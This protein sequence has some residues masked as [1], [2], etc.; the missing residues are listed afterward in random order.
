[1]VVGWEASKLQYLN[2]KTTLVNSYRISCG[3]MKD[4]M[5]REYL[6]KFNQLQKLRLCKSDVNYS[7][8]LR[9][10]MFF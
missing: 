5:N 9:H 6:V 3:N 2:M 7:F 1:M 10:T 4:D 8:A